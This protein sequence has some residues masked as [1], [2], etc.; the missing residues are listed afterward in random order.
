MQNPWKQKSDCVLD[1]LKRQQ[2]QIQW[3]DEAPRQRNASVAVESG[4]SAGQRQGLDRICY[5]AQIRFAFYK[6]DSN[7]SKSPTY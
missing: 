4:E 1:L 5:I 3:P 2:R 6:E 7:S